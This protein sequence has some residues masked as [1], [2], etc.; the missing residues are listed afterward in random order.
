MREEVLNLSVHR[1]NGHFFHED[2]DRWDFF[3]FLNVNAGR[4]CGL[5]CPR[6]VNFRISFLSRIFLRALK[7]T[8]AHDMVPCG[9]LGRNIVAAGCESEEPKFPEIIR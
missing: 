9:Q 1:V 4:L 8:V 3:S 6:I 7:F 5:Q 2:V